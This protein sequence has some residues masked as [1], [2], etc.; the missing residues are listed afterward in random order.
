MLWL[1]KFFAMT[2]NLGWRERVSYISSYHTLHRNNTCV[3]AHARKKRKWKIRGGWKMLLYTLNCIYMYPSAYRYVSVDGG[4]FDERIG[5][6]VNWHVRT[7]VHTELA[8]DGGIMQA[9]LSCIYVPWTNAKGSLFRWMDPW[10]RSSF[11]RLHRGRRGA[12]ASASAS[13]SG[14]APAPARAGAG[15]RAAC[16]RAPKT[17]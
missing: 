14:R 15:E 10:H 3:V 1:F 4:W 17:K 6:V 11:V 7:C 2:Y 9:C 12:Y 5:Y 16:P 8:S 13:A